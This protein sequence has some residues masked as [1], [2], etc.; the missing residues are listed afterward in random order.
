MPTIFRAELGAKVE[1][2]GGVQ[3]VILKLNNAGEDIRDGETPYFHREESCA[4][5]PSTLQETPP[6][7]RQQKL[8]MQ[9]LSHGSRV[10]ECF[11]HRVFLKNISL[12]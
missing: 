3:Q 12:S 4:P 10:K 1:K 6:S 7:W 5:L 11:F 9:E 2:G 8:F